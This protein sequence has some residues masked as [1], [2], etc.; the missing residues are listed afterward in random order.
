MTT[1]E[2]IAKHLGVEIN[3]PFTTNLLAKPLH[4]DPNLGVVTADG[5]RLSNVLLQELLFGNAEVVKQAKKHILIAPRNYNIKPTC[6]INDILQLFH[7]LENPTSKI[8]FMDATI[9]CSE[10]I[11]KKHSSE[12]KYLPQF[13]EYINNC[14][15]YTENMEDAKSIQDVF[16]AGIAYAVEDIMK[17]NFKAIVYNMLVK[18]LADIGIVTTKSKEE[19]ERLVDDYAHMTEYDE[20]PSQLVKQFVQEV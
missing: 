16:R 6:I 20:I 9:T 4:V 14:F 15:S 8:S 11:A 1:Q 3:E 12:L 10:Q 19:I 17:D 2:N 13:E 18:F 7:E 5:D